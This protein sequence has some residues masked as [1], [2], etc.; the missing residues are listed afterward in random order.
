MTE[1]KAAL[2]TAKIAVEDSVT[3]DVDILL[4]QHISRQLGSDKTDYVCLL[5]SKGCKSRDECANHIE[6]E[7]LYKLLHFT[8]NIYFILSMITLMN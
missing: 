7:F 3:A 4:E 2:T 5:C 8:S 1:G 6:V